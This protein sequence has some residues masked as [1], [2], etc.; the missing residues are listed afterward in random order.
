MHEPIHF[1]AVETNGLDV[2]RTV[3]V[4]S[5]LTR[6]LL[7]DTL[8]TDSDR[9]SC[10]LFSLPR[11]GP[12]ASWPIWQKKM[13]ARAAILNRS[14]SFESLTSKEK[15]A[16]LSKLLV[17]ARALRESRSLIGGNGAHR[18]RIAESA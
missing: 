8:G 13:A 18:R 12:A 9:G 10:V 17:H 6:C 3:P 1:S 7:T 2:D 16:S 5:S 15:L 4:V 14:R 11:G